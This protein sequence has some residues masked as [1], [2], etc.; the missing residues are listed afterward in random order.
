M[1]IHALEP[2]PFL[3]ING[4]S[5]AV[6]VKP[7]E[8]NLQV[9]ESTRSVYFV[10]LDQSVAIEILPT[11]RAPRYMVILK[12]TCSDAYN[13]AD[14]LR[15]SQVVRLTG[16]QSFL[17]I[18]RA[19]DLGEA[20]IYLGPKRHCAE[21]IGELGG[22][23]QLEC[24]KARDSDLIITESR[25]VRLLHLLSAFSRLAA[26]HRFQSQHLLK[27]DATGA[28]PLDAWISNTFGISQ[29]TRCGFSQLFF[30]LFTQQA[31]KE[32]FLFC[33]SRLYRSLV[34][35]FTNTYRIRGRVE[36]ESVLD[37]SVQFFTGKS[38]MVVEVVERHGL[39]PTIISACDDYLKPFLRATDIQLARRLSGTG[40]EMA[41]PF[42]KLM[43][44]LHYVLGTSQMIQAMFSQPVAVLAWLRLIDLAEH[45]NQQYRIEGAFHE[46]A[47]WENGFWLEFAFSTVSDLL[48]TE[49]ER[50]TLGDASETK[51]AEENKDVVI[52]LAEM[53]LDRMRESSS[54]TAALNSEIDPPPPSPLVSF[55]FPLNRFCGRV[56]AIL[57]NQRS[58]HNQDYSEYKELA[59]LLVE[60]PVRLLTAKGEIASS[61]WNFSGE[62]MIERVRVYS[63]PEHL[64]SATA[65]FSES[66]R[67][68]DLLT[69][70]TVGGI[71][72]GEWLLERILNSFSLGNFLQPDAANK[73]GGVL[74][75]SEDFGRC[76]ETPRWLKLLEQLLLLLVEVISQ[77][78]KANS[79]TSDPR[80]IIRDQLLH[81]LTL[82]KFTYSQLVRS[83]HRSVATLPV[84]HPVLEEVARFLPPS[85][86]NI[87]SGKFELRPEMLSAFNPYYIHFTPPE[88]ERA[89]EHYRTHCPKG[90]RGPLLPFLRPL[91]PAFYPI[92]DLLCSPRATYTFVAC[93]KLV[94]YND[95][96]SP[97]PLTSAT[98]VKIL[99][100][101]LQLLTLGFLH[102]KLV[103]T[104]QDNFT[105]RFCA[106]LMA[107]H[108]NPSIKYDEGKQESI[109]QLLCSFC[110]MKETS[111]VTPLLPQL[112]WLVQTAG[113]LDPQARS[114]VAQWRGVGDV[115]DTQADRQSAL[116]AQQLKR[117]QQI[118][119]QMEAKRAKF[120]EMTEAE[121]E[122]STSRPEPV[123]GGVNSVDDIVHECIFCRDSSSTRPLGLVG[124]VQRSY[125]MKVA[126]SA[127]NPP[128]T[129]R[130][131]PKRARGRHLK[132]CGHAMHEECRD[133]I[134]S[135]LF[136]RSLNRQAFEGMHSL[137]VAKGEFLCP[138]CK[139]PSNTLVP[140][141][142]PAK[143]LDHWDQRIRDFAGEVI[144]RTKPPYTKGPGLLLLEVF[145][146]T[147]ECLEVSLRPP[148]L[149]ADSLP[150]ASTSS[151]ANVVATMNA[152]M[153]P[154]STWLWQ[155][156]ADRDLMCIRELYKITSRLLTGKGHLWTRLKEVHPH[157]E[158]APEPEQSTSSSFPVHM[159]T[160][161][162]GG[163]PNPMSPLSFSFTVEPGH[164]NIDLEALQNIFAASREASLM[165]FG[166]AAQPIMTT[167]MPMTDPEPS[168][169]APPFSPLLLPLNTNPLLNLLFCFVTQTPEHDINATIRELYLI[170]VTQAVMHIEFSALPD[171]Q[172]QFCRRNTPVFE[173]SKEDTSKLSDSFAPLSVLLRARFRSTTSDQDFQGKC[174]SYE[175]IYRLCVSFLRCCSLIV[176]VSQPSLLPSSHDRFPHMTAKLE[177][178]LLTSQLG[179]P[180]LEA[181]FVSD[182]H[183]NTALDFVARWLDTLYAEPSTSSSDLSS[184]APS[185]SSTSST[186]LSSSSSS[187][188]L[189]ST[190]STS[191]SSSTSPGLVDTAPLSSPCVVMEETDEKSPK[192]LPVEEEGGKEEKSP[193][194]SM[195]LRRI[196]AST[197]LQLVS[198]PNTYN[199]LFE[200]C[201]GSDN[202]HCLNCG[203]SPSVEAALC[204]VCGRILCAGSD[205]CRVNQVGEVSWHSKACSPGSGLFLLLSH[206]SVGM[207]S[208]GGFVTLAGS[209]FL[210]QH[211]EL[212]IGLERGRALFL[213]QHYWS[214]LHRMYVRHEIPD[215]V[216][217]RRNASDDEP[218]LQINYL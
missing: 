105:A 59:Q 115:E 3:E 89:E 25:I 138:L 12:G 180:P 121:G 133:S 56:L 169:T 20:V 103:G 200:L 93:L 70:Q 22:N 10:P 15:S 88:R 166:S 44:D 168:P 86:H 55:H 72:G 132:I 136:S 96:T 124:R 48:M 172:H 189:S 100:H 206:S 27:A 71:M 14:R 126:E 146:Y 81:R 32:S 215:H 192:K 134:T 66:L 91:A 58:L 202:S 194:G 78:N 149:L 181:L 174:C 45:L 182:K 65:G 28:C 137:R 90:S 153:T 218:V 63:R 108:A 34:R 195:A 165:L 131:F 57:I 52:R 60:A 114:C 73:D 76:K 179:L 54:V 210:D 53:C 69:L 113:E 211:G 162:N 80:A 112:Q 157:P 75:W 11:S 156:V 50:C 178:E 199:E 106:Q 208:Q 151:M 177:C 129:P 135:N 109:L 17:L 33:Y 46:A 37:L 188:S 104:A 160:S 87:D 164:G 18:S 68:L 209:P 67:V 85:I 173:E 125:L 217:R 120:A 13:F 198:L 191:L 140:L 61:L 150:I 41:T 83:V 43:Q 185:S 97:F 159:D 130:I 49:L 26:F 74:P 158:R 184:D 98:R 161:I 110:N 214:Q 39:L 111:W 204:L 187:T 143:G 5:K 42:P 141:F 6:E 36:C 145:L 154:E 175:D 116:R 205:C 29:A 84:F 35:R 142:S 139:A 213:S 144:A 77:R 9:L 92:Y 186:S 128:L 38:P 7:T 190:S 31:F 148:W 203:K 123:V 23:F 64:V 117:K 119:K 4:E 24:V 193:V 2:T 95:D 30:Q 47:G 183:P 1:V 82:G 16:A 216:S 163:P 170:A 101:T 51:S 122:E 147:L 107:P 155:Q 212:D 8:A 102:A 176:C 19:A 152:R 21:L 127:P 94:T 197:P 79:L 62:S 201:S 40:L 207:I 167:R 171:A 118:L 196:A 99:Q